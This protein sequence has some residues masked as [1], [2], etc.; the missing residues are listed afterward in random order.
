MEQLVDRLRTGRLYAMTGSGVSVSVGYRTCKDVIAQ[1][2]LVVTERRGAVVDRAVAR[3]GF[4]VVSV[5]FYKHRVIDF[6]TKCVL[7]RLKIYAVPVRCQLH[8]VR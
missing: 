5:E 4:R 3:L 2:A 8:A 7:Y 6:G 1:L